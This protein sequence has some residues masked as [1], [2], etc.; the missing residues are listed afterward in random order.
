MG[1]VKVYKWQMGWGGDRWSEEVKRWQMEWGGEEVTPSLPGGSPLAG[2][3][4]RVSPGA[5]KSPSLF[6]LRFCHPV[7]NTG[8]LH[9]AHYTPHT[10]HCNLHTAH[11]TLHTTHRTLIIHTSHFTLHTSYWTLYTENCHCTLH[12]AHCKLHIAHFTL[13]VEH[14]TLHSIRCPVHTAMNN[15][16]LQHRP[17]IGMCGHA[18]WHNAV[19]DMALHCT[20]HCTLKTTL[21]SLLYYPTLHCTLTPYYPPLLLLEANRKNTSCL[22]KFIL[23]ES[24]CFQLRFFLTLDWE[25]LYILYIPLYFCKSP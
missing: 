2:Q 15:A 10:T 13:Q 17:D 5:G 25:D 8:T 11:Y 12:P 14:C 22:C 16:W 1:P 3:P 9:T 21:Y 7:N 6:T 20:L 19:S 24:Q 18:K 23:V 4:E